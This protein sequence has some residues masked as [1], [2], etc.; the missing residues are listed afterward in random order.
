MNNSNIYGLNAIYTADAAEGAAEGFNFYR[1][2]THVDTLW[3]ASGNLLFVPNREIGT[4]TTAAN[5]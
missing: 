5:S 1:D 2:A 4:N 3:V